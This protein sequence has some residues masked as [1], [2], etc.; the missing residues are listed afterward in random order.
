MKFFSTYVSS[1]HPSAAYS[2]SR[3]P[4][5]LSE[6]GT[7]ALSTSAFSDSGKHFAYAISQSVCNFIFL[8]RTPISVSSR[9]T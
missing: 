3:K 6:D 1:L 4:N 5:A 9:D 2:L 7:A 8:W